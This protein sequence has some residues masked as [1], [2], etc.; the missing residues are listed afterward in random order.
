MDRFHKLRGVAAPFPFVNI[1]TDKIIPKQFLKTIERTGLSKGLF[2]ELRY[3]ETGER[4]ED[5]VLHQPPYDQAQILIAGE[6][7]G[8]GSSRE[9]APQALM[10]S[11]IRAIVGESFAA[12]FQQNCQMLGVP[13]VTV[14]EAVVARLQEAA[15]ADP[16]RAYTLDLAAK[17]LS[18]DGETIPVALPE[19]TRLALT[20]GT[21]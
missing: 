9:H 13:A 18:S 14:P 1:D 4:I 8:C 16:A 10:R 5:F 20:E 7:F 6:N 11:G 21:W 3:T 19:P 15:E 12:I 2:Y 17:T